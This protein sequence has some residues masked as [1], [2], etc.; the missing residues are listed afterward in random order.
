MRDG[1]E[2]IDPDEPIYRRVAVK[3]GYYKA[4]GLPVPVLS[5][6]RSIP[7]TGMTTMEYRFI[8]VRILLAR[9][10][11]LHWGQ[12]EKAFTSLNCVR[13]IYSVRASF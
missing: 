9:K 8:A 2:P 13:V 5:P 3:S 4:T 7:L 6:K 1:T 12:R 11:P 10:P